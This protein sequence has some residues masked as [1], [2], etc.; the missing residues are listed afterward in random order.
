MYV[1]YPEFGPW[2]ACLTGFFSL[3][4]LWLSLNLVKSSACSIGTNSFHEA[5]NNTAFSFT[6]P[7]FSVFPFSSQLDVLLSDFHG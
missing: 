5:C 1:I 2:N 6:V 3:P 7:F 4:N